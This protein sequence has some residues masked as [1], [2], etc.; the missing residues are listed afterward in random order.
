MASTEA[1]ADGAKKRGKKPLLLG[2]GL[3]AALGA[4]GF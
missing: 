1:A 2:L 4:G 3:A